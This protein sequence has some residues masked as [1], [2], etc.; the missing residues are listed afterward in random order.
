MTLAVDTGSQSILLLDNKH[1]GVEIERHDLHGT[2]RITL[3]GGAGDD[4]FRIAL[5]AGTLDPSHVVVRGGGHDR[6]EGPALDTQWS[7]TREGAGDVGNIIFREIEELHGSDAGLERLAG[8]G[9]GADWTID[10]DGNGTVAD[11]SFA[12][13]DHLAGGARGDDTFI[14]TPRGGETPDK[15]L[16]LGLDGGGG[17]HD[18]VIVQAGFLDKAAFTTTGPGTGTIEVDGMVLSH[19]NMTHMT[20]WRPTRRCRRWRTTLIRPAATPASR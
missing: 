3:R 19:A 2:D 4:R 10:A 6:L 16:E 7:L 13:F 8:P 17:K 15:P 11:T 14:V 9:K 20:C 1:G 12:D 5:D 18:G